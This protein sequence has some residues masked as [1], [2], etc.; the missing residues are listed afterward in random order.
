[1]SETFQTVNLTEAQKQCLMIIFSAS[2]AESARDSVETSP[3]LAAAHQQLTSLGYVSEFSLSDAGI[4]ALD[5]LGLV[6]KVGQR[7]QEGDNVY[8]IALEV[9]SEVVESAGIM[10]KFLAEL[11]E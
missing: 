10:F 1:M 8:S 7:T 9:A 4:A 11:L 2:S 6:D 5:R 3:K